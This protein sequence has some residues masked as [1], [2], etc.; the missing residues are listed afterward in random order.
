MI[1]LLHYVIIHTCTDNLCLINLCAILGGI[2]CVKI[3]A[4]LEQE[5]GFTNVGRLEGGI[6]S[7]AKEIQKLNPEQESNNNE[8]AIVNKSKYS[9]NR[10]ILTLIQFFIH[11][12]NFMHFSLKFLLFYVISHIIL[13]NY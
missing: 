10:F 6:I 4:Y 2:R 7:Y 5:L 8:T 12:C 11:L 3:N 1:C 13:I 9:K